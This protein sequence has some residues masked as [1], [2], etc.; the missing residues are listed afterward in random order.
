MKIDYYEK[1][2]LLSNQYVRDINTLSEVI[3][4]LEQTVMEVRHAQQSGARWYTKGDDG[5]FQQV[6][7]HLDRADKS[8]KSVSDLVAD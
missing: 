1:Y 8:I 4:I 7:L 3:K 2:L 6:R 5:L